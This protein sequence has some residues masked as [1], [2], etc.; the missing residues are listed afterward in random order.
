MINIETGG[1]NVLIA[2]LIVCAFGFII[3]M[4]VNSKVNDL[5]NIVM[6]DHDCKDKQENTDV[7]DQPMQYKPEIPDER[8]NTFFR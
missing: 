3:G 4:I 1:M 2:I 7:F 5:Y 8:E 6:V